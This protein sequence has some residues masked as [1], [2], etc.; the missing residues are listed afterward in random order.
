MNGIHKVPVCQ[1]MTTAGGPLPAQRPGGPKS[2]SHSTWSPALANSHDTYRNTKK[3][4]FGFVMESL[5]PGLVN[6]AF[7]IRKCDWGLNE[8]TKTDKH[9]HISMSSL[10]VLNS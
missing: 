7:H 3:A 10:L 6:V 9:W 5:M 2:L 1:A 8:H 4:T